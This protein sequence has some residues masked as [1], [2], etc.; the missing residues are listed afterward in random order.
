[1]NE[2]RFYKG[3]AAA[4]E[5]RFAPATPRNRE[6]IADVLADWMP[7]SGLVLEL[8]SGTGEHAVHFANRFPKLDWQPSDPDAGALASIGAWQKMAGLSNVRQPLRIDTATAD[9]PVDRADAILSINMVHIS[10]WAAALGLIE[11]AARMLAPGTPLILYGPWIEEGVQTAASNL[12]FD[13]SLRARN[14]EWG[15]R[16]VET[17][18]EEAA[19]RRLTLAERRPMPANNLMLLLRRD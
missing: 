8:A 17:F 12:A 11:G 10:P 19:A 16:K 4:D 14:S 2:R 7:G 1:M 18:A 9:W 6:P 13:Q 3:A 15:L 5:R